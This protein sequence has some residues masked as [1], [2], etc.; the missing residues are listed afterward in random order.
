MLT[1][2]FTLIMGLDLALLWGVTAF[3]LNYVPTLG[4]AAA[5]VPPTVFALLQF[6]GIERAAGVFFGVGAIQFL[7]GNFVDPKIEGRAVALS[8][9]VVLFAVVLWGWIWGV[10]GALTAVPLTVTIVIVC[11]HFDGTRW[12][13]A[14]LSEVEGAEREAASESRRAVAAAREN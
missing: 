6:G 13:A 5:I 3:L 2:L 12:V 9:V 4:P 10:L 1:G 14:L 8:P 7:I 11:Q